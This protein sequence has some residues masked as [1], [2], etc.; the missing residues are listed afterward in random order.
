MDPP[1]PI[2]PMGLPEDVPDRVLEAR[3]RVLAFQPGLVIEERGTG[4]ARHGQQRRERVLRLESNDGLGFQ[5][6]S[7]ALKAR[8]FFR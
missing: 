6:R 5:P 1:M 8:N 3:V 4:Q 2:T 7:C